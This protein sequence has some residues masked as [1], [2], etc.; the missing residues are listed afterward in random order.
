MNV[1]ALNKVE[2][3]NNRTVKLPAFVTVTPIKSRMNHV[4][5]RSLSSFISAYSF[6]Y[7]KW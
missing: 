5:F 4:N 3:Y 7:T 2:R 1:M 6:S